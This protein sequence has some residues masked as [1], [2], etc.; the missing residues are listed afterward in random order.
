MHARVDVR[1]VSVV[2]GDVCVRACV[3]GR[4]GPV[5]IGWCN[6]PSDAP[7]PFRFLEFYMF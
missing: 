7:F 6:V 2:A 1:G 5:K 3:G 4:G